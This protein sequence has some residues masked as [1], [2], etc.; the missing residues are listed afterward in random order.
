MERIAIIGAG[1]LGK[2][3]AWYA[4]K[5]GFEV[6]AFFDDYNVGKTI[7]G[8]KVLGMLEDIPH[9]YNERLFDSLV[10][11][12]GYYHLKAREEV[13]NRFHTKFNIPFAT[14]IDKTCNVDSSAKI[15]EGCVLFPGSLI[16]KGVSLANNVLINVGV[17]IAHDSKVLSHSFVCPRVAMA[18]FS[19]IGERCMVGINTTIIDN[20]HISND[21]RKGGTIVTKNLEK[22]GLYVGA[23]AIWKKE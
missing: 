10:C 14:I 8:I 13:Y 4:N 16:D 7:D 18:G 19:T 22:P 17:T 11:G 1:D 15:G 2:S 3:I 12:I 5:N 20:V 23:P 9:Y 21:I 6:V